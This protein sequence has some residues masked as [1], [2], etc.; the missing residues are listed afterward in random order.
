MKK[1]KYSFRDIDEAIKNVEASI[2][3]LRDRV[4]IAC[5]TMRYMRVWEC[6]EQ[7]EIGRIYG[8]GTTLENL[9]KHSQQYK[10]RW[11]QRLFEWECKEY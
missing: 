11:T 9:V 3:E 7:D 2:K 4:D 10:S 8:F 6:Q 1:D 5:Q